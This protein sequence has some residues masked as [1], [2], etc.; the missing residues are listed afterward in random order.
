MLLLETKWTSLR[1]LLRRKVL[2]KWIKAECL[3]S[4]R[5]RTSNFLAVVVPGSEF[6]SVSVLVVVVAEDDSLVS[7]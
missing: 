7:I 6:V 1:K 5:K 2:R 4:T 3:M